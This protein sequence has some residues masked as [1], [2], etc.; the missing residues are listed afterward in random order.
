MKKRNFLVGQL[1]IE[2]IELEKKT[3]FILFIIIS[4]L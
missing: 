1:I 4:L 2:L 3:F